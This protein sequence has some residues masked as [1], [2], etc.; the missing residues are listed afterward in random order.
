LPIERIL[1]YGRHLIDDEDIN[2]VVSV[3]RG[4]LIT[5]GPIVEQFERELASRVNAK[6]AVAVTSGTAALHVACLAA[7]LKPGDVGIT[8]AMTFAASANAMNYCGA[9]VTLCDI[10]KNSLCMDP[11]CLEQAIS[12]QPE[13]SVIMPVHFG[14]L[15][16]DMEKIRALAGDRIIIEDAAHAL[17]GNYSCG[18]PV[19]C[20]AYSDM[21]TFSFHPVKP[22]TTG[23]GGA[24]VTNNPKLA[25]LLRLFRSHGIEKDS[26]NLVGTNTQ[27]GIDLQR[28]WYYEQQYLGFNYR[29]TDIQA[30]LG[31]S[32]I[33]K[34]KSFISERQSI[35][36]TYDTAFNDSPN[37]S[38]PQSSKGSRLISGQHLYVVQFEFEEIGYNREEI[39]RKLRGHNVG[40]QVHYIPLYHHPYHAK[41]IGAK[42]EGFPVT[43]S[44]YQRCL[45]IPVFP[46][47]SKEET[48]HVIKTVSEVTRS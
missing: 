43:E 8:S 3:L 1:N 2:Q 44:Y 39:M 17:G 34:L 40:S 10:D 45:S 13:A 7:G 32:Q 26:A 6:F 21:C 9:E 28:P 46:G 23:E 11:E 18:R 29:L 30:A 38:I 27:S 36:L 41:R 33:S 15:S 4:D 16:A 47:M 5:Q 12:E 22:I 24:I 14:G 37:I 25:H 35:A 20:G 42:K 19:G 48:K 31:L